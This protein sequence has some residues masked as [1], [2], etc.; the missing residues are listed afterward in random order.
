MSDK[1]KAKPM[2]RKYV[3]KVSPAGMKYIERFGLSGYGSR[4][5]MTP[6]VHYGN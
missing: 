5:G 1:R 4:G 6:R 2:K 3:T